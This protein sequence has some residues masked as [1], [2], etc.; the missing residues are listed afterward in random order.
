MNDDDIDKMMIK[1]IEEDEQAKQSSLS[2]EDV[3]RELMREDLA[4]HDI[5]ILTKKKGN[6]VFAILKAENDKD[7]NSLSCKIQ[8]LLDQETFSDEDKFF[9]KFSSS[10]GQLQPFVDVKSF[11]N[12]NDWRYEEKYKDMKADV[13]R[14]LSPEDL[15]LGMV[16][17]CF[18][19]LS[20]NA[21]VNAIISDPKL[22]AKV[23]DLFKDHKTLF[24]QR[25]INQ[26][27]KRF[28]ISDFEPLVKAT[29]ECLKQQPGAE[30]FAVMDTLL[31]DLEEVKALSVLREVQDQYYDQTETLTGYPPTCYL[32]YHD[33][34]H[35]SY[36]N[37]DDGARLKILDYL[38][39]YRDNPPLEEVLEEKIG[40]IYAYYSYHELHTDK[41]LNS[42][43][44]VAADRFE[45]RMY[46]E[47]EKDIDSPE[48]KFF[49]K[50]APKVFRY[51][52]VGDKYIKLAIHMLDN[53]QETRPELCREVF[54]GM[55]EVS[56]YRDCCPEEAQ[57][58]REELKNHPESEVAKLYWEHF[59]TMFDYDEYAS[60]VKTT[61]E[62]HKEDNPQMCE[63]VCKG[64]AKEGKLE[65]VEELYTKFP[66]TDL[67]ER[68]TS[69]I[70]KY[71][72]SLPHLYEYSV[73]TGLPCYEEK[74]RQKLAEKNV[75]TVKELQKGVD[76]KPL[77]DLVKTIPN[78]TT[79]EVD[80]DK[81]T[82]K[83]LRGILEGNNNITTV[84]FSS[85]VS[86]AD[87]GV[88]AKAPNLER[89]N[90]GGSLQLISPDKIIRELPNIKCIGR[91][92]EFDK[93]DADNLFKALMEHKPE[94]LEEIPQSALTD[95]QAEQLMRKY[96]DMVVGDR[97]TDNTTLNNLQAR[98]QRVI[99]AKTL[100]KPIWYTIDN[101]ILNEYLSSVPAEK[102]FTYED[103][104]KPLKAGD[105]TYNNAFDF[106]RE[107]YKSK[108]EEELLKTAELLGFE[109][110][111]KELKL[112]QALKEHRAAEYLESLPTAERP[113]LQQ[114][115]EPMQFSL[116]ETNFWE[117]ISSC[118]PKD[119]SGKSECVN[120]ITKV[121]NLLNVE[122]ED[123]KKIS[124]KNE[125]ITAA[126]MLSEQR[127]LQQR[128]QADKNDFMAWMAANQNKNVKD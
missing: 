74:L 16:Y 27:M 126:E 50:H 104:T 10:L 7:E 13:K 70:G 124:K 31:Y 112:V 65:D 32:Y 46:E 106:M 35:D 22:K 125:F 48:S 21:T 39:T 30:V 83:Q 47:L 66:N 113:T 34:G 119:E 121:L 1:M 29:E 11:L 77:Y 118:Y 85:K 45:K 114:L 19:R 93:V 71:S 3:R 103:F 23:K 75:F 60:L 61:I 14:I 95:K 111:E 36:W 33:E 92:I 115:S 108:F 127:R 109:A 12:S 76:Y 72:Y 5:V 94:N 54:A 97:Y 102:H 53:Y 110:V 116:D 41:K 117:K 38:G 52:K 28:G 42:V 98:N 49:L 73:K 56:Y 122:P 100:E 89:I 15:S 78:I 123:I 63:A 4:F 2:L 6:E 58:V 79:I 55:K 59:S 25:E 91:N 80:Q 8:K 40:R 81:I 69:D 88:L 26:Y 105:K 24:L 57:R 18:R 120:E 20:Q 68:I 64:F 99:D 87:A 90:A 37:D 101:K 62:K 96:P 82:S 107:K 51:D 84:N 67:A 128:T 9:K 86:S 43:S 17:Y 44:K